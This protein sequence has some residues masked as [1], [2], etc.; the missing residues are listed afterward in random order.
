MQTEIWKR[1]ISITAD[2]EALLDSLRPF[3]TGELPNDWRDTATPE[4]YFAVAFGWHL[5]ALRITDFEGAELVEQE[6]ARRLELV[7]PNASPNDAE[8]YFMSGVR[9]VNMVAPGSLMVDELSLDTPANIY[10]RVVAASEFI[11]KMRSLPMGLCASIVRAIPDQAIIDLMVLLIA[12]NSTT[13]PDNDELLFLAMDDIQEWVVEGLKAIGDEEFADT[14]VNREE[15][16]L[17]K[18][19]GFLQGRKP[20]RVF[21]D[22]LNLLAALEIEPRDVLEYREKH[23]LRVTDPFWTTAR[24][25]DALR[26]GLS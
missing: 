24:V 13:A 22:N 19:I 2:T 9:G 16:N 6:Y 7:G 14:Y 21:R 11:R 8:E 20:E 18:K 12:A 23:G 17:A 5:R 25:Q 3:L 1:Q 10:F 26:L 15:I 4:Q